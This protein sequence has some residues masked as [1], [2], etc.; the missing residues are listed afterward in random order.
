MVQEG[1]TVLYCAFSKGNGSIVAL[2]KAGANLDAQ[3]MAQNNDE[4]NLGGNQHRPA[5]VDVNK[6]FLVKFWCTAP[7]RGSQP[8]LPDT[9]A[10]VYRVAT[11]IFL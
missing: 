9:S 7:D 11:R 4:N 6:R 1:C 8:D 2:L 3:N 5:K 10:A